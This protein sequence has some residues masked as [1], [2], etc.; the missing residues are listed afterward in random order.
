MLLLGPWSNTEKWNKSTLDLG[1]SVKL[2]FVQWKYLQCT[3]ILQELLMYTGRELQII[4]GWNWF[5]PYYFPRRGKY[6][7]NL[8]LSWI[9]DQKYYGNIERGGTNMIVTKVE[10][11]KYYSKHWP[12]LLAATMDCSYCKILK[13]GLYYGL[14]LSRFEF[15]G[16]KYILNW[17]EK[18]GFKPRLLYCLSLYAKNQPICYLPKWLCWAAFWKFL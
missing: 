13:H 3:C 2:Y 1:H 16:W 10:H 4:S 7:I 5:W 17:I 18:S 14:C 9:F 6:E 8:D 15:S 11:P 12:H